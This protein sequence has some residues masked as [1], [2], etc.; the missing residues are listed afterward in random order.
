MIIHRAAGIVSGENFEKKDG[1][2]IKEEDFSFLKGPL[3]VHISEDNQKI[4]KITPSS[5]FADIKDEKNCVLAED[6]YITS[7]F[8]DSHTHLIYSGNR[9]NEHFARWQGNSYTEIAEQGGGIKK[10][11][12]ITQEENS[13]ELEYSC[14]QRL[15]SFQKAGIA[16]TEIK[17]GYG[18]NSEEEYRLIKTINKLKKDFS[19]YCTFLGLHALPQNQDEKKWVDQMIALLPK[20]KEEKLIDFVDAFPEKG[21]FSLK[22]SLRFAKAATD[23]GFKLRVHADEISNMNAALEFCKLGALS[24]DHLQEID[25]KA[26]AALSKSNTVATLLPATSFYLNMNY[27]KARELIEAGLC[28]SIASDNNPG[29]APN[30]NLRFAQLLAASHMQM[31]LAEILCAST[32]SAA[33]SLGINQNF[34]TVSEGKKG[35]LLLWKKSHSNEDFRE[36]LGQAIVEQLDPFLCL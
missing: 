6:C 33:K 13:E 5:S 12:K 3:D 24:V 10:T 29:T 8:I 7:A 11:F 1:R 36:T 18:L 28:V 26:I 21:F 2:K 14:R 16:I 27:A 35:K 20:L 4:T 25:D 34:G 22:E 15:N 30:T 23:H 17:S 9:A 31:T 19:L 32:Y